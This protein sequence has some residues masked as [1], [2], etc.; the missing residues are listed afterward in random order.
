MVVGLSLEQLTV[1]CM[2][3]TLNLALKSFHHSRAMTTLLLQYHFLH[4]ATASSL[5]QPTTRCAYGMLSPALN[6][7]RLSGVMMPL[8][9]QSHSPQTATISSPVQW[10]RLWGSVMP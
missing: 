9:K 2:Y 1:L 8:F 3:G 10:T 4:A 5:E 6:F 7:F